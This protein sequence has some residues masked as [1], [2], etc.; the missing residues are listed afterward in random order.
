MIALFDIHSSQSGKSQLFPDCSSRTSERVRRLLRR[1][2]WPLLGV[3]S[4]RENKMGTVLAKRVD[5]PFFILSPGYLVTA[6]RGRMG[7][8][9]S[10]SLDNLTSLPASTFAFSKERDTLPIW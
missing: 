2:C 1:G 6:Q 4:L 5:C 9:S 3:S 10:Y 8:L 7:L